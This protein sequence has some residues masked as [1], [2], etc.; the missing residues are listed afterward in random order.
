MISKAK[1]LFFILMGGSLVL[2][3]EKSDNSIYMLILERI[4]L[5]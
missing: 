5:A 3:K 2:G 4:I 1:G